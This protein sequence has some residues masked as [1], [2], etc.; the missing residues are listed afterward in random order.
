MKMRLIART[1]VAGLVLTALAACNQAPGTARAVDTAT[2][3][4]MVKADIRQL[5]VD[6]NAHDAAKV[7]G[8]DAPDYVSMFHGVANAIGPEADRASLEKQMTDPAT[9]L[10]LS[11]ETVD[12][13]ASGDLAVYR[14]TYRFHFTNPETKTVATETGN[15]IAG[16]KAQPDGALKLAWSIGADTGPVVTA[17][18]APV[19]SAPAPQERP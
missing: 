2:V 11:D 3:V 6:Y 10:E 19:L 13:A 16:Y 5:V 1:A 17:A 7:A 8:H 4:E 15:W 18:P 12:V 9:R 14:A